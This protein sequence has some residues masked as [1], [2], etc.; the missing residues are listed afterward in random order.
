MIK[1]ING[2]VTIGMVG[3]P[4]LLI[5]MLVDKIESIRK[6][7]I[8]HQ[9]MLGLR[10]PLF[11]GSLVMVIAV[12]IFFMPTHYPSTS[13]DQIRMIE[14][15]KASLWDPL[16]RTSEVSQNDKEMVEGFFALLHETRIIR[17]PYY[18]VIN[19]WKDL[20]APRW[21][22]YTLFITGV[23]AQGGDM[24]L[25]TL[26]QKD[27]RLYIEKDRQYYSVDQPGP[28]LEYWEGMVKGWQE[29]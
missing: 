26:Y 13:L 4:I 5:L 3:V 1:F 7:N 24:I 12:G 19:Q 23:N 18:T 2:L 14:V 27:D 20:S 9:Y 10:K 16:Y 25:V 29:K 22:L 21:N 6:K 11:I 17:N 28:V 15:R 8:Y